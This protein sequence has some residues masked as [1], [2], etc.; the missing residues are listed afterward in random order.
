MGRSM[1]PLKT[2]CAEQAMKNDCFREFPHKEDH[3]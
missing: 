2:A 3:S 1:R